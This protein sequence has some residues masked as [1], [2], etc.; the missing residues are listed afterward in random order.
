MSSVRTSLYG[1]VADGLC[2]SRPSVL[3]TKIDFDWKKTK[4]IGTSQKLTNDMSSA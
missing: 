4:D 3:K 1:G 2:A